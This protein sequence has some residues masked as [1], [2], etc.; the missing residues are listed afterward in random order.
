MTK[1]K[2]FI[3][4]S[5]SDREWVQQLAEAV[6]G[7]GLNVWFDEFNIKAGQ[8]V[9]KALEKGLR[10]SEVVAMVINSENLRR[11]NLFFEMGAALGM[12][13]TIIPIVPK[14]IDPRKLPLL[15]QNIKFLIRKAPEETAKELVTAVGAL[16]GEPA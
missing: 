15:L 5:H 2:V 1:P 3:S 7:L 14:D 9:N 12:T 6:V 8:S 16:L 11:P 13:K 10:E 4:Y